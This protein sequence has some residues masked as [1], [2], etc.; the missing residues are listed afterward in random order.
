MAATAR[1]ERTELTR[2]GD[3]H[4]GLYGFRALFAR[5]LCGPPASHQAWVSDC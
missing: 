5:F 3:S 2:F 4:L 1:I